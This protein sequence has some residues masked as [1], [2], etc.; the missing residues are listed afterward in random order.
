MD[1]DQMMCVGFVLTCILLVGFIGCGYEGCKEAK[2]M[3]GGQYPRL[4]RPDPVFQQRL[5]DIKE[6]K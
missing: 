1:E 5:R 2:R 3:E 6:K 4:N